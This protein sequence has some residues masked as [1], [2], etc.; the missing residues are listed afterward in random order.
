MK[1]T[2]F[3]S[4]QTDLPNNTNRS[5]IE[6]CLNIVVSKVGKSEQFSIELAIDRDTKDTPG[7]PEIVDT[8]F[9]KIESCTLFV[10]DI[11][12]INQKAELRKTPNPNVLIELGYAAKA[13]GWDKIICIYNKDYGSFDDLPFDLRQRRPLAYCLE[14]QDRAKVKNNIADAIC[15]TVI[16]L[17]NKGLLY[18]ELQDYLKVQV[19]TE[20]LTIIK[21]LSYSIYGYENYTFNLQN[22]SNFL[23]LTDEEIANILKNNEFI[24][25]QVLKQWGVN[26]SC[27]REL[28]DKAISSNHYKTETIKPVINIIKWLGSFEKFNSSRIT[29]NLFITSG[30]LCKKYTCFSGA[31]INKHNDNLPDRYI[32]LRKI[33]KQRGQVTDFGDFIEKQRIQKLLT[34]FKLNPKYLGVYVDMFKSFIEIANNWLAIT[35]GEFIIDTNKAFEIRAM[36]NKG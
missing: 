34:I 13:I 19:D 3:Y 26:E 31:N 17:D 29:P 33:D 9:N 11:S 4:W 22:V 10:A 24:G 23:K 32:L 30:K 2:I 16:G 15:N 12:I 6:S 36:P 14:G 18:D 27:L 28:V 5:F 20:I 25:F 1:R 8:I 35:N 7:T 21:H